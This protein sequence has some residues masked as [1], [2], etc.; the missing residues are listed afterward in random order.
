MLYLACEARQ[1]TAPPHALRCR[2]PAVSTHAMPKGLLGKVAPQA[3]KWR[4]RSRPP[5]LSCVLWTL[6]DRTIVV[7]LKNDTTIT[8]VLDWSDKYMK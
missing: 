1:G 6:L 7:E 3:K 5:T 4:R 8:G 2:N